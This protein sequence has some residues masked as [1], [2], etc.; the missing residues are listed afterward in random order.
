MA[1]KIGC[2]S[3][4]EFAMARST[5]QMAVYCSMSSV[6]RSC[7]S[8]TEDAAK[9]PTSALGRFLTKPGWHL[10]VN[11]SRHNAVAFQISQSGREHAFGD[12][13]DRAHQLGKSRATP[14]G[15]GQGDE[16]QDAPLVSE[17]R[18][19]VADRVSCGPS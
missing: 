12:A 18:E 17:A 2:K 4:G 11:P 5:S 15:P 3:R 1:S 7:G 16:D 9:H 8:E 14:I 6:T 13:A 10:R 19:K